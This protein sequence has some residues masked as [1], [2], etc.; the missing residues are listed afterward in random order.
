MEYFELG[1]IVLGIILIAPELNKI[2]VAF[3]EEHK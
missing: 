2:V 1:C 3:V